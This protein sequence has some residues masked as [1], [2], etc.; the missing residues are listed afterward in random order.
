MP[1]DL[2]RG[3]GAQPREENSPEGSNECK[4]IGFQHVAR[5]I[6]RVVLKAPWWYGRGGVPSL[7]S[8]CYRACQAGKTLFAGAHDAEK[9]PEERR[10]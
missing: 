6:M 9:S 4:N 7:S 3:A 8:P 10:P 1:L 2:R 5:V